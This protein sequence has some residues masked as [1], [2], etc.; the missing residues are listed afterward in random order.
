MT[1]ATKEKQQQQQLLMYEEVEEMP[2]DDSLL[3]FEED[4]EFDPLK[5][6]D[7]VTRSGAA[8]SGSLIKKPTGPSEV[9]ADSNSTHP[10][11][12]SQESL[13]HIQDLTGVDLSVTSSKT[14]ESAQLLQ[15]QQQDPMLYPLQMTSVTSMTSAPPPTMAAP[16]VMIAPQGAAGI[17]LVS[18]P[19][20]AAVGQGQIPLTLQAGGVGY[21][22]GAP[23]M[24]PVMYAAAPQGTPGMMYQVSNLVCKL[25]Q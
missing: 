4:V 23:A 2:Q 20:A 21:G 12:T 3:T 10:P 25:I 6:T 22:G 9:A 11:L 17:Q 7:S 18:M 8:R 19:P 16:N 5:R 14:A 15:Q 1:P 13:G 24:V